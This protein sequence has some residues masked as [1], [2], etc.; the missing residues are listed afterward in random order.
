[1]WL[2][3]AGGTMLSDDG[4][5]DSFNSKAGLEVADFGTSY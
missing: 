3:Q 1:M 5:K 2:Q 4:K